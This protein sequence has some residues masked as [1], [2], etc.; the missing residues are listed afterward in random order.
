MNTVSE[1]ALVVIDMQNDFVT[2][3]MSCPGT[4][5][6]I[7]PIN[8]L[9]SAF[10]HVL[11]VMDWHPADHISL[12]R[13][14]E[15]RSHWDEI[16]VPYGKQLVFHDHCIQ[17]TRGAQ[18]DERLELTKAEIIFRKGHRKTT[19]SFGAFYENDGVPTGFGAYCKARGFRRLYMTGL[20][21]YGCVLESALGAAKDGFEVYMVYDATAG[22]YNVEE[23]NRILE[24][25]GVK[26][27]T[28]EA[29]FGQ[30]AV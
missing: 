23:N 11:V 26:W 15:G 18:L 3:A 5:D 4:E 20:G 21:R 14:H 1:D 10:D 28:S 27:I 2:G 29:V 9:A 30:I 16:D 17:G 8:R 19:D 22:D 12:A 13:N 25:A 6:I 7:D 24:Q